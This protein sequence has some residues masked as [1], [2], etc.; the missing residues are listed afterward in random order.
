MA[1][2]PSLDDMINAAGHL[3][4]T[5]EDL[6]ADLGWRAAEV[7]PLRDEYATVLARLD[8]RYVEAAHALAFPGWI[9]VG[10]QTGWLLYVLTRL[11]R[12][13]TVVETGVANGHGSFVLLAALEANGHGTLHSFDI[14]PRS[15]GLVEDDHRDRWHLTIANRANPQPD[16]K[17]AL[18]QIGNVD[19]FFHDADHRYLNQLFEYRTAWPTMSNGGVF[20][21]D[22]ID[23]SRAFLHFSESIGQVPKLLFD[24][25]KL[26]GAHRVGS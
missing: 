23:N 17:R 25:K 21:S 8:T 3:H 15:G 26:I 7:E 11:L 6:L 4:L 22:D 2:R 10:S 1:T 5:A 14:E 20:L 19:L 16:F 24:E 12:P 13:R 9:A 18:A